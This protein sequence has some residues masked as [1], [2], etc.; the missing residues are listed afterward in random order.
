MHRTMAVGSTRPAIEAAGGWDNH[1]RVPPR[2][3]PGTR[4]AA[5]RVRG[6]DLPPRPLAGRRTTWG[7][8]AG[9]GSQA[10]RNAYGQTRHRRCHRRLP[11]A[12]GAGATARPARRRWRWGARPDRPLP[13]SPRARAVRGRAP[14]A[15]G[16]A[17]APRARHQMR[18]PRP[19]M[20]PL[21][22]RVAVWPPPPRRDA[23]RCRV[24]NACRRPPPQPAVDGTTSLPLRAPRPRPQFCP[25]PAR[26]QRLC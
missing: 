19:R 1:S 2:R 10:Q 13:P 14:P 26:R 6:G 9:G 24:L 3:R 12:T 18:G 22:A 5:P 16:R 17:A 11:G 20:V 23:R 25:P 4:C 7:G 21:T 15:A 8:G